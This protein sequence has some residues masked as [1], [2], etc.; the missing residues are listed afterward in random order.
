MSFIL[1]RFISSLMFICIYALGESNS[2]HKEPA[3]I[4]YVDRFIDEAKSRGLILN[5]AHL[6]IEFV[7]SLP[8]NAIG[9]CT[10][11]SDSD[12]MVIQVLRSYWDVWLN[13][14]EHWILIAHESGHCFLHLEHRDDGQH[15]MNSSIMDYRKY[16][17][18][19]IDE[20]FND[21]KA[22]LKS[23]NNPK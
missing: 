2:Y 21:G 11:Y 8:P 12:R 6:E 10:R 15:I 3:L 5:S 22:V 18:A 14:L 7:D 19:L 1:R 13:P 16:T 9:M 17:V 4:P 20:E 23:E